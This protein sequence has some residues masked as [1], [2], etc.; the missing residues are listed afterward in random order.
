[1]PF[2]ITS[3]EYNYTYSAG[4]VVVQVT[5]G[6]AVLPNNPGIQYFKV[7]VIPSALRKAN[8]DVNIHSYSEIKR[9][10]GIKEH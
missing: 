4:Q 5:Q 7:V 6:S 8:P 10:W 1:M 9:V 3:Q 2:S